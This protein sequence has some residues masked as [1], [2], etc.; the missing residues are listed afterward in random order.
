MSSSKPPTHK[1]L[2]GQIART[3]R[4]HEKALRDF[5]QMLSTRQVPK[6]WEKLAREIQAAYED[7]IEMMDAADEALAASAAPPASRGPAKK[8]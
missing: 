5:R 4:R 3:R 7:G 1:G 2:R 6:E 8:G